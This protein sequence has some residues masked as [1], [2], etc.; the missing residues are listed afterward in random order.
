MVFKLVLKNS[1]LNNADEGR[2]ERL[3]RGRN[4]CIVIKGQGVFREQS[5]ALYNQSSA[6]HPGTHRLPGLCS[7][8]PGAVETPRVSMSQLHKASLS[9]FNL[10]SILVNSDLGHFSQFIEM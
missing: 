3:S 8:M 7:G 9:L 10:M 5:R 1:L 2:H 4:G 6:S